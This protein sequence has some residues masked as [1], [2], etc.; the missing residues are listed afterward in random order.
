M[1]AFLLETVSLPLSDSPSEANHDPAIR[2]EPLHHEVR[3]R[4]RLS[5]SPSGRTWWLDVAI[6]V[7]MID[8]EQVL[9]E[10]EGFFVDS[11]DNRP[12]GV[13][14]SVVT[15]EQTGLVSALEIAEGQFG[16][17]RFR[18]SAEQIEL[19]VPASERIVVR[20]PAKG[21]P[22]REQPLA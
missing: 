5:Q 9:R 8:P 11:S 17:R 10:C 3:L 2:A 1:N 15:D 6:F 14:D 19:V 16:H 21:L 22:E 4:R 12:V 13:V 20:V 7:P 18:V